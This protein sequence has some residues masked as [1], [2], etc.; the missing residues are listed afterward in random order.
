MHGGLCPVSYAPS[1]APR[2][3]VSR[4][5]LPAAS[6]PCSASCTPCPRLPSSALRAPVSRVLLPA[7]SSPCSAFCVLRPASCTPCPRAR[8]R[9]R[10]RVHVHVFCVLRPAPRAPVPVPASA[11]TCSA[12]CVLRP[13]PASSVFRTRAP[14]PAPAAPHPAPGPWLRLLRPADG[15]PCSAPCLPPRTSGQVLP[16]SASRR[17][18]KKIGRLPRGTSRFC[19]HCSGARLTRACG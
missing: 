4:V 18:E 8:A 13:T 1:P 10:V 7:A 17:D 19:M 12:F 9:V 2:A 6:S 11:S 16:A 14:H 3:R 5:L 15:C